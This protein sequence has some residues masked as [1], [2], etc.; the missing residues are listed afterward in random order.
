MTKILGID[1]GGTS[2]KVGIVNQFGEIEVKTEIKNNPNPDLLLE[3]L[4]NEIFSWIQKNGYNFNVDIERIGFDAP[5]FIDHSRGIVHLSGNL[6]WQNFDLKST[7]QKIFKNKPVS[8]LNDAN[9]AALGEFWTGAAKKYNSEIFY[10]LGTGIGGAIVLDG[11]LIAGERGFAGEFGHG[12]HMQKEYPCSCGLKECLEP[13]SSA[14]GLA[15]EVSKH[16]QNNPKSE[17]T[18][19]FKKAGIKPEKITMKN[20]AEVYQLNDKPIVLKN[21]ILEIYRPLLTH[22]SLMV[23]AFDPK[24]IIIGGG[25]SNMGQNLIDIIREGLNDILLDIFKD[26]VQIEIAKLGNDAGIVGAAY[27][28]ITD[29]EWSI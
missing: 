28:A 4:G 14:I 20:I 9:A 24:A 25:G 3:H 10:T 22:M 19:Y 12:G 26:F 8:I 2:A 15:R 18:K 27:Y 21:L 7:L 1:L 13:V 6:K 17:V 29:W 11:K 5:G 23:N 16:V